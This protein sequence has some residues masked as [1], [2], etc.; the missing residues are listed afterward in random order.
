MAAVSALPIERVLPELKASLTAGTSAVLVA[1][2]G[3]GKTTR[4]PLAL[5]N[6]PWLS[7]RRIVMLE[8]RRLAAKAAASY[9]AKSLG[10]RA[11]QTVGYRVRQDTRV[12]AQT[13]IEVV[14]EGVLTR[15]LQ[16]DPAL[17]HV[18]AVIFDEFHERSLHADL[19][20]ALCLQARALLR[21]ELR[22]VVMSA[23]MDARAVASLIGGAP[24]IECEGRM[25]PVKTV[26]APGAADVRL[27]ERVTQLIARALREEQ[28]DAL[29]FLPG[30]REIRRVQTLAASRLAGENADVYPLYGSLSAEAQ[31]RALAPAPDGRRKVVL[32]TTIAETSLTVEG[33]CIVIDSG[34]TRLARYSPRTGMSRLETAAVS[35]DSAEQRKGRAGRLQA[36]VC[37]RLWSEQEHDRLKPHRTPEI[38]E[39]DLAQL[40]LELL[41]WGVSDPAELAWLDPPPAP[42]LAQAKLLLAQLGAASADGAAVTPHGRAMAEL[43]AQPRLA[44]MVL[45][46][47]RHGQARLACLLTALLEERDIGGSG[48]ADADIASRVLA[49][50][51]EPERYARIDAERRR[52]ENAVGAAKADAGE[53]LDP[54][55]CG[56]VLSYAYP[57][58]IG[59]R[60]DN[61]A[62]LLSNGRG[63]MFAA[64]QP[65]AKERYIVAA[66]LDDAGT[67][68][69]IWR[70][71][72]LQLQQLEELRPELLKTEQHV[73]WDSALQA[74][75][76]RETVAIGAI[77]LRDRPINDADAD[78]Q[79]AA[80][81]AGIRGHGL[82]LLPWTTRSRQLLQRIRFM[83]RHDQ[84]YP[85][86]SEEWLLERLEEWLGPFADGC[87]SRSDL[88]R[89]Q[90]EPIV[91]AMLTW[92]QAREI[93]EQAPCYIT[94]PSGARIA[95]D[96]SDPQQPALSARLQQMFGLRQTPRVA[97]GRVA[98]TIKLL[99]PAQRPVQITKDLESFWGGAYFEVKK[100][101][102]GR[103]P[104]HYWP[105]DPLIAEPTNRAKPKGRPAP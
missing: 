34:L 45:S 41:A 102:K 3:A 36:G 30:E 9:M 33:V 80:L 4:V 50:L 26:Y 52:W 22:I 35:R 6:E 104:K 78:L 82:E 8:P 66:E 5:L 15:M 40:A 79:R 53:R 32:A 24:I 14:T 21:E 71:A 25:Y 49:V 84:R 67:E 103:Y 17:E 90:M 76:A 94:V 101:L 89:L 37:Y 19:G 85:H 68:G 2:P 58:R 1:S 74:V 96:Y 23:T 93:D 97:N 92:E 63:A 100:D 29:V 13:R 55:L 39:T 83:H 62:Y 72:A 60:R 12:S 10:E 18:G 20:L 59:Q 73:Y 42:A 87:K 11:G 61:G 57:D 31:E 91:T 44:H 70:A 47:G 7:G 77:A 46:A 27:E 38:M 16:R 95:I 64:M 56:L 98:I 28:G 81:L 69:R 43:G 65:L 48:P 88:Q 75:R 51:R 86:M 105:D 99:S 54:A